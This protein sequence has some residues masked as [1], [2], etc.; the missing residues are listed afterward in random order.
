MLLLNGKIEIEKAYLPSIGS[1][2][3]RPRAK[4]VFT[5][6]PPGGFCVPVFPLKF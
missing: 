5:E 4:H 1:T 2:R 3:E 6:A